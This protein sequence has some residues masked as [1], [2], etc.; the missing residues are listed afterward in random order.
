MHLEQRILVTGGMRVPWIASLRSVV[1]R[2]GQRNLR[3][4]CSAKPPARPGLPCL[5]SYLVNRTVE[6]ELGGAS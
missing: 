5:F 6:D 3:R 2:R 4:Q 1:S